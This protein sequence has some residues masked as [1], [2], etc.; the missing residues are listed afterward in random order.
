MVKT[1]YNLVIS[2]RFKVIHTGTKFNYN[3]P[4]ATNKQVFIIVYSVY[5]KI[6]PCQ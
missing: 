4:L 6:R 1:C 3:L 5:H 2:I